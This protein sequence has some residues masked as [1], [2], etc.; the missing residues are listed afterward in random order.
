MDYRE[1]FQIPKPEQIC[2]MD[3][4]NQ[5]SMKA[6]WAISPCSCLWRE[7][8][9]ILKTDLFLKY[10]ILWEHNALLHG[11]RVKIWPVI[12]FFLPQNDSYQPI[13]PIGH[14]K[15]EKDEKWQGPI[16]DSFPW[17]LD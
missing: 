9:P 15:C 3:K 6:W 14:E 12:H 2:E 17:E 4:E 11:I 5:M 8:F 7:Y 1:I 16:K 10:K 13:E